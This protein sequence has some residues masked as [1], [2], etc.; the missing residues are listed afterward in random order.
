MK[1]SGETCDC[2]VTFSYEIIAVFWFCLAMNPEMVTHHLL[3]SIKIAVKKK[4][5]RIGASLA[6]FGHPSSDGVTMKIP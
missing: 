6:L 3:T 2:I 1:G 5:F 4:S